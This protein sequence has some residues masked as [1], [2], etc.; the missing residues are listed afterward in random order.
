MWECA[1]PPIVA[2][3]VREWSYFVSGEAYSVKC[4]VEGSHPSAY[5]KAL[6]G[7]REIPV[8][9]LQEESEDGDGNVVVY[10]LKFV[11]RKEDHGQLLSC[12]C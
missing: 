11:P 3:L 5:V 6:V 1:V 4:R 2:R 10:T 8:E 9:N 12:R 7:G